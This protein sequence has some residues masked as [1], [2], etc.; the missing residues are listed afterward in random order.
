MTATP[1]PT[2]TLQTAMAH[3][4]RLLEVDPALAA[5]QALEILKVLPDHPAAVVLLAAARRRAGDPMAAITVLEPLLRKHAGAVA[6]WF[7]YGLA[8]GNAARDGYAHSPL[9]QKAGHEIMPG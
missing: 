3:A 1:E 8:L 2:G 6:A 7:E 9:K 4:T 5:E